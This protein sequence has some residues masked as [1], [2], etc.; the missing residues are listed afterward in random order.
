M[1]KLQLIT[2]QIYLAKSMRGGKAGR[3]VFAKNDIANNTIFHIDPIVWCKID[4]LNDYIYQTD[5]NQGEKPFVALGL[6]SLINCSTKNDNCVWT[7]NVKQQMII[8][9][10]IKDIKANEEL[11]H[12]YRYLEYDADWMD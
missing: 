4:E 10:A 12:D 11:L 2:D 9:K 7:T 1:A 8:F 6:S 3:G 5:K